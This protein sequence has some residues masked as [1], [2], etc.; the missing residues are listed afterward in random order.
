MT[1]AAPP[2]LLRRLS[3]DAR[4]ATIV[5]LALVM[6]PLTVTI[7]TLIDFG[8]RMYLGS[9]VEGTVHRAARLATIG[10]ISNDDVD[11]YV[12]S[13]LTAFSRY[14]TITIEKKSYHNFS[15]VGKPEKIVSDTAPLGVY[16]AG[17][18]YEDANGNG[19]YDTDGGASGIGGADDIVY[20]KVTASF[21]RI[22]P[23]TGFL[24]FSPSEDVT[25]STVLRN[26]PF[27]AQSMASVR[28][29]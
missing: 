12:R 15:Y 22:V 25:S 28:C 4:G 20:Y 1:A 3:R 17:D 10:N 23:L 27:A 16:N 7:L 14:A 21:P 6:L 11:A 9:V 8:Y 24:G 13:Q 2:G 18:C 5:E 19:R 26:Q 29:N